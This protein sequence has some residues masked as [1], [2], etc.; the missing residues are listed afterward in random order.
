[1]L[2]APRHAVVVTRCHSQ[3]PDN[4]GEPR[5]VAPTRHRCL[6]SKDGVEITRDDVLAAQLR[7]VVL[8]TGSR[9]VV[10][11]GTLADPCTGTTITFSK[12]RVYLVPID[13]VV[14]LALAWD[15]GAARWSQ[16]Q[17]EA[18]ANDPTLVLL[19][20][21]H[22]NVLESASGPAEWMPADRRYW[23]AYDQRIVTILAHYRLEDRGRQSRHE[24]RPRALLTC[25]RRRR[26][27]RALV[28]PDAAGEPPSRGRPWRAQGLPE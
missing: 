26:A 25:V 16:A 24:R 2:Q 10:V 28:A 19:A 5:R 6:T 8:R 17:R 1:M 20:V 14:P 11:A 18:Y 7:D 22:S 12:S 27:P 21:E 9:C 23:C 13:H 4:G 15:L 3:L